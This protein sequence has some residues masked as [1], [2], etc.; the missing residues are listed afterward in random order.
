M[1]IKDNPGCT[2]HT[3]VKFKILRAVRSAHSELITL[4]FKRADFGPFK[5]LLVA[6]P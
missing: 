4:V 3:V 6:V 2:E 1:R 5:G